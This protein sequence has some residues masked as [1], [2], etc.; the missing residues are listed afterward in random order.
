M[1]NSAQLI[2]I[3]LS[4][5]LFLFLEINGVFH[6][7]DKALNYSM[8]KRAKWWPFKYLYSDNRREE[9]LHGP[10]LE[11]PNCGTYLPVATLIILQFVIVCISLVWAICLLFLEYTKHELK[12][13]FWSTAIPFFVTLIVGA[14]LSTVYEKKYAENES[15]YKRK[16]AN[17][18]EK[19]NK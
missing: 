7:M 6:D 18:L 3:P 2:L 4:L 10:V 17:I 15:E 9:Y 11:E 19:R 12:I 1:S 13:L 16:I 5:I 8:K 14:I